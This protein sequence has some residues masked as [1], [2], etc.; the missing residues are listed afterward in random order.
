MTL[1][2]LPFLLSYKSICPPKK[3]SL[4]LSFPLEPFLNQSI[5]GSQIYYVSRGL[6][7]GLGVSKVPHLIRLIFLAVFAPFF[8]IFD[9]DNFLKTFGKNPRVCSKGLET[10]C[11]PVLFFR[12]YAQISPVVCF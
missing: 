1:I 5:F 9:N 6:K 10:F 12:F 8:L 11:K 4:F 7:T 2:K 3:L